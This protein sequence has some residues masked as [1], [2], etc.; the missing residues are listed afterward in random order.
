MTMNTTLHY[1]DYVRTAFSEDFKSTNFKNMT[2][3]I[4][5]PH[6]RLDLPSQR[7]HVFKQL[8]YHFK[9]FL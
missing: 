2:F 3:E 4:Q 5:A 9:F 6:L 1:K 7:F 8:K